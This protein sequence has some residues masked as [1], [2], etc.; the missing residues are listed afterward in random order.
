M[1][2][3]FVFQHAG[4]DLYTG[5]YGLVALAGEPASSVR[6]TCPLEFQCDKFITASDALVSIVRV[7][8]PTNQVQTIYVDPPPSTATTC[9]I[10]GT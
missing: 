3:R 8:N 6:P 9:L 7:H 5:L 2:F 1:R 10:R 4:N